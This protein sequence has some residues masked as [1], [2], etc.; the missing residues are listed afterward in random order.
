M[1]NQQRSPK[2]GTLSII[3][4]AKNPLDIISVDTVG[5]FEGYESNQKYLHLAIDHFTRFLWGCTSK[6]QKSFYFRKLL[7]LVFSIGK[8]EILLSDNYPGIVSKD[9]RFFLQQSKIELKLVPPHHPKSNSMIERANQ[10]LT[11]RIRCKFYEHENETA[12]PILAHRS[13]R[14]YNNTLHST[15]GYSPVQFPLNWSF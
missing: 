14:E 13:I 8:P 10:T 12:W 6:T 5:G 7:R 2:L 3:G 9:F 4:S 11:D 15:T 1:L